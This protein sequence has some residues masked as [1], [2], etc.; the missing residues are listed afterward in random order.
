[1]SGYSDIHVSYANALE[2]DVGRQPSMMRKIESRI[3]VEL[4]WIGI[5]TGGYA[6]LSSFFSS[7]HLSESIALLA[8]HTRCNILVLAHG[9][10]SPMTCRV[11][12]TQ[13]VE[14]ALVCAEQQ[15]PVLLHVSS[16]SGRSAPLY[17]SPGAHK[18]RPSR[19]H[20]FMPHQGEPV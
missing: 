12:G 19:D 7:L 4:T 20:G 1:M 9:F 6:P 5:K 14:E 2:R 18:R 8:F 11:R 3:R 13:Q 10:A 17:H 15:R 16:A